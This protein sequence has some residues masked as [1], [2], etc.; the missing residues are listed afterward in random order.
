MKKQL[1]ANL[2]REIKKQMYK[3]LDSM[4]NDKFISAS[5]LLRNTFML[6]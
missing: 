2:N 5:S 6:L 4:V 3:L 1:G